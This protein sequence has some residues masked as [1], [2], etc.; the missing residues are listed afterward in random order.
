MKDA[1]NKDFIELI[2]IMIKKITELYLDLIQSI[3][4]DQKS[5]KRNKK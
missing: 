4:K 3:I 5:S 1:I 2:D